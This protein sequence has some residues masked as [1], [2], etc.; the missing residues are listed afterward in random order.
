[1]KERKTKNNNNKK[2]KQ[3]NKQNHQM[4]FRDYSAFNADSYLHDVYAIDRNAVTV[5][6][7]G[8]HEIAAPRENEISIT[9]WG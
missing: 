6:C 7:S 8:L 1:M 4:Y 2:T 5:Q 3:T 9:S